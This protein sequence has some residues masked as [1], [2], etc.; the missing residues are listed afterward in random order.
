MP[1][2]LDHLDRY[3]PV[4]LA[5]EVAI[6]LLDDLNP[7]FPS[8]FTDS[9]E[10]VL[11][12][13]FGNRGGGESGIRSFGQPVSESAPSASNLEHVMFRFDLKLVDDPVVLGQGCFL[14]CRFRICEDS[15]G[16]IISEDV[17]LVGWRDYDNDGIEDACDD[18]DDNDGV[19]DEEDACHQWRMDFVD[20]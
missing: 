15:A 5:G 10:G 13:V 7:V 6:V 8:V 1:D 20:Q 11:I 9:F 3:D 16:N 2:S 17:V 4:E 19:P 14:E 18:D 12:L